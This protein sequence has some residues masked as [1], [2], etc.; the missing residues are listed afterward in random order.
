[1][2]YKINKTYISIYT[3]IQA[4]PTPTHAKASMAAERDVRCLGS[5]SINDLFCK[6][7][8]AGLEGAQDVTAEILR[9]R[10]EKPEGPLL[11]AS[12][13][14]LP[15]AAVAGFQCWMANTPGLVGL[16]LGMPHRQHHGRVACTSLI[17]GT[18]LADLL[19]DARVAKACEEE[20]ARICGAVMGEEETPRSCA[21]QF[22]VTLLEKGLDPSI[23]V[24]VAWRALYTVYRPFFAFSLQLEPFHLS[25]SP[26]SPAQCHL[27]MYMCTYIL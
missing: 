24:F 10:V 18:S 13:V 2:K 5:S 4:Q 25:R 15:K 6:E 14:S 12:A 20:G 1:M 9:P 8:V 7:P 11:E 26:I 17:V 23:V 22:L 19:A 3:Y 16:M 27:S 21:K